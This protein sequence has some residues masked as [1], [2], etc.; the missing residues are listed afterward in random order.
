MLSGSPRR[1][2]GKREDGFEKSRHGNP[3][4]MNDTTPN[5]REPAGKGAEAYGGDQDSEAPTVDESL[6]REEEEAAAGEAARIGGRSGMEGIEEAKRSAAEHGGGE[7]E[8]FEQAEEL[9]EEHATHGDSRVDPLRDAPAAEQEEDP[10]IHGEADE[11]ES[12]ERRQSDD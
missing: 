7:A 8:G 9:L 5:D 3:R 1:R 2:L 12:T 10:S 4:S 6:I 11:I